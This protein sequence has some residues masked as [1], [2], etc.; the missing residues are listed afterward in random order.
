MRYSPSVAKHLS[1]NVLADGRGSV[2]LQ[3]H[4]GLQQVLRPVHFEVGDRGGEPHPLVL[5]VEH[6]GFLVQLVSDEVDS[7][8][9]G[10]LVAGVEAL[11]AE[12]EED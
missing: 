9:P 6:H 10:V 2:K 5:D 8:Q 12:E 7:P 4:V 1:S 11:E 3:K